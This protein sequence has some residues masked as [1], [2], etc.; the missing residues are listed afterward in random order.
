MRAP[1]GTT[2]DA[3]GSNSEVVESASAPAVC[4]LHGRPRMEHLWSRAVATSGNRRQM[5][6]PRNRRNQAKTVAPGCDRLPIGAHGKGALPPWMEGSRPKLRKKRGRI[7]RT[8]ALAG[9]TSTL[10]HV[11]R[12]P[13]DQ[14][15]VALARYGRSAAVL[16]DRGSASAPR[17]RSTFCCRGRLHDVQLRSRAAC[18]G[19]N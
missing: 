5:G 17:A 6:M 19:A 10:H 11:S 1:R 16:V 7:P 3:P 15:F 12:P 8:R 14:W 18:P 4:C 2:A 13:R 9:L